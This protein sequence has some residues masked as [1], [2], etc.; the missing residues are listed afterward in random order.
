[1]KS[2]MPFGI[3]V[4]TDFV[5]VRLPLESAKRCALR[6]AYVF[7]HYNSMHIMNSFLKR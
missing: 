2:C 4:S 3:L 1:M 7:V 6:V 5:G